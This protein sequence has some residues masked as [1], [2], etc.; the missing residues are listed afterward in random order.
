MVDF[1]ALRDLRIAT[2]VF[3]LFFIAIG[4]AALVGTDTDPAWVWVGLFAAAGL[5]GLIVTARSLWVSRA[6]E[7]EP[8]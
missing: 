1:N 6:E 7:R 2:L 5:A 4:I 8:S 3:G